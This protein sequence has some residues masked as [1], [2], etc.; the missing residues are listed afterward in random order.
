MGLV[1]NIVVFCCSWWLVFFMVI[2]REFETDYNPVKGTVKSA[3]KFF[4]FKNK[5]WQV[6]KITFWLCVV[7]NILAF[8][9]CF[10]WIIP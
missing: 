7:V 8:L 5:F 6:S 2:S 1:G 3:P 9:G 10:E 4:S